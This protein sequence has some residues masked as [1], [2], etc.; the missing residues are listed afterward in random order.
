MKKTF[1]SLLLIAIGFTAFAQLDIKPAVGFN[2]CR[3]DSKPV[4]GTDTLS[5]GS[6]FG[7]QFG[8]SVAIGRKM[9]IEPGVFYVRRSQEFTS[10]D[11]E[12]ENP[13]FTYSANY[14]RV[15]VNVGFQFIGSTTSFAGLKIFVGPSMF[16]PMSVKDNDYS[17]VKDQVKSPQFDFSVGAGLNIWFLFLD[18]SYGWDLTQQFK[19]DPITA[20][21]QGLYTNLGFRFRLKKD[22]E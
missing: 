11:F 9:Y 20:K 8:A 7:Y 1:I 12:L 4:F 3:F 22:E 16:I 18:V 14:L 13:K 6:M 21:M 15:P 10:Q 17:I 19:D 5:T 2:L